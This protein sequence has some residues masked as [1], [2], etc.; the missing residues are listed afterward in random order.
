MTNKKTEDLQNEKIHG[1]YDPGILKVVSF[2]GYYP[3]YFLDYSPESIK[4][5]CTIY[6]IQIRDIL[7]FSISVERALPLKDHIN[8]LIEG[9]INVRDNYDEIVEKIE[10]EAIEEKERKER[11]GEID[12]TPAIDALARRLERMD[13]QTSLNLTKCKVEIDK[14]ND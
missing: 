3:K 10:K 9:L 14:K 7:S 8:S 13:K 12:W 4:Y 11:F 1:V 5:W 6:E 2:E